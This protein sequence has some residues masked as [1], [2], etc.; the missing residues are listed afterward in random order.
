M[1]EPVQPNAGQQT[2]QSARALNRDLVRADTLHLLF[3]QSHPAAYISIL[4]SGLLSALLWQVT[5]TEVLLPWLFLVVLLGVVRIA[6]FLRYRFRT[7]EGTE[8]LDWERPYFWT[9]TLSALIWGIGGLLVMPPESPVH[10][11]AVYFCLIGMA[12]GAISVYSA[13]R[14]MVLTTV[15]SVLLPTTLWFLLRGDPLS[16]FLGIGGLIFLGS[17][18]RA[19]RVLSGALQSSFRLAHELEQA[20]AS[21]E[22]LARIDELTGLRNRRAFFEQAGAVADYCRRRQSSLGL[23][24]ID[25]DHFKAVND[26]R[27]HAAGDA[28]LQQ[29]AKLLTSHLR[30]SDISARLGGEEF[31]VVLPDTDL[32]QAAAIAEKLRRL[33][34]GTDIAFAADRFHITASIGVSAG[35]HDI[36]LLMNCADRALYQAK[37]DGRNRIGRAPCPCP[38]PVASGSSDDATTATRAAH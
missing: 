18:P 27:S 28:A 4:T 3:Q 38:S 29:F 36:S 37:A 33:I 5:A 8:I 7:P 21:A 11:V 6:M 32:E 13:R 35:C 26:S 24:I 20:R 31:A 30:S 1:T 19:A 23:L 15:F 10:Q 16:L 2:A 22:A 12:G 25:L 9:L 34:A 14:E 17:T